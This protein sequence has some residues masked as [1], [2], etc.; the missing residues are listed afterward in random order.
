MKCT[1]VYDMKW[2]CMQAYITVKWNEKANLVRFTF[3]RAGAHCINP[4]VWVHVVW[5]DPCMGIRNS[6]QSHA[7]HALPVHK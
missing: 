2:T 4:Q 1:H 6:L 3:S 5:T 7:F